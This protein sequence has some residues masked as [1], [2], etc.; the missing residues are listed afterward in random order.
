M[1]RESSLCPLPNSHSRY[2]VT[3]LTASLCVL[4]LFA[5]VLVAMHTIDPVVGGPAG[6]ANAHNMSVEIGP[7]S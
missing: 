7:E 3:F 6:M 1:L 5:C 2:W 4:T